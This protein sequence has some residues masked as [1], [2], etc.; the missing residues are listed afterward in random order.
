MSKSSDDKLDF[1]VLYIYFHVQYGR[2]GF[3]IYTAQAMDRLQRSVLLERSR[4][5]V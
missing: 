2:F 5:F 3:I 1:R 4:K